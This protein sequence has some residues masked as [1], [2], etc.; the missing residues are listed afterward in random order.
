MPFPY[1]FGSP[2]TDPNQ[3]SQA[4]QANFAY[5]DGLYLPKSL[6]DAKGDLL[7]GTAADTV[8]RKAVGTSMSLLR[9]NVAGDDVEWSRYAEGI[10]GGPTVLTNK[11]RTGWAIAAMQQGVSFTNTTQ[12]AAAFSEGVVVA[13]AGYYQVVGRINFTTGVPVAL[14]IAKN[15]PSANVDAGPYLLTTHH[16][17]TGWPGQ[18]GGSLIDLDLYFNAGDKVNLAVYTSGVETYVNDPAWH[19]LIVRK[20]R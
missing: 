13:D 10:C 9:S 17:G 19:R 11:Y 20:R 18:T 14:A 5:A 7:V 16:W 1:Q 12:S 4:L 15:A 3:L 8:A 2:I 6:V